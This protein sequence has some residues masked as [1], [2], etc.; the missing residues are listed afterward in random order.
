[1]PTIHGVIRQANQAAANGSF[2]KQ[3]WVNGVRPVDDDDTLDF[4]GGG[5][6]TFSIPLVRVVSP[7]GAVTHG[8]FIGWTM[9]DARKAL[10]LSVIAP[11]AAVISEL[12]SDSPGDHFVWWDDDDDNFNDGIARLVVPL[13][14]Q[15]QLV[16]EEVQ[17]RGIRLRR[18]PE[19]Q[20]VKL[21]LRDWILRPRQTFKLWRA[22]RAERT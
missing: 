15:E 3:G 19:E 9:S 1:M 17:E 6:K 10:L 14:V 4:L 20:V 13:Q 2:H 12:G 22:R 7:S 5:D 8:G 16:E 18:V 21:R 11:S